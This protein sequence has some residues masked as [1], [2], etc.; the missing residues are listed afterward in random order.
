M[1]VGQTFL[2]QAKDYQFYVAWNSSEVFGN[3]QSDI[4]ASAFLESL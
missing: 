4:Q 2:H 1:N 3:I